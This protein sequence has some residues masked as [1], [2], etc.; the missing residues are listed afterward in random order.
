[1]F[2]WRACSNILPTKYQLQARGIGRDDKCDLCGGCE[3]FGHILREC[4][5]AGV[6]W[7]NTR[8]KLPSLEVTPR[9]FVDICGKS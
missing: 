6:V 5:M 4:K 3:T 8:L 2:M 7:G 9:D 1:M